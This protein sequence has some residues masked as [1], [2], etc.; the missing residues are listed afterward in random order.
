MI[1]VIF[2]EAVNPIC[3][4]EC[5]SYCMIVVEV[6]YTCLLCFESLFC[7]VEFLLIY[8]YYIW[9]GVVMRF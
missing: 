4:K 3:Y 6:V 7:G 9:Y 2:G 8:V 1:M 5:E